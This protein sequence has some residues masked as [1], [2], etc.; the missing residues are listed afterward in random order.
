[1]TKEEEK[2]ELELSALNLI[3]DE[4]R[5]ENKQLQAQIKVLTEHNTELRKQLNQQEERTVW[6]NTNP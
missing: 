5:E 1:M 2:K 6:V 4:L 3:V